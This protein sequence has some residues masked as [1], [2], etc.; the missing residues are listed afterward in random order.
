MTCNN[1][2]LDNAIIKIMNI[3]DIKK[4]VLYEFFHI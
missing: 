2:V 3:K 1:T 4:F